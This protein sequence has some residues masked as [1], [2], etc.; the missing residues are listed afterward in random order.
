MYI[1][2][3]DV[4]DVPTPESYCWFVHTHSTSYNLVYLP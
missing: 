4:H 3:G 2:I 1:D